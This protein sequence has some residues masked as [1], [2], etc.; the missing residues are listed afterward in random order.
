MKFIYPKIN[1]TMLLSREDKVNIILIENQDLFVELLVDLNDQLNGKKGEAVLSL[2]NVPIPISNNLEIITE[3][4][5]FS[6]N[7]NNLTSELHNQLNNIALS[8]EYY[9]ESKKLE[10]DIINFIFKI[11]SE[12]DFNLEFDEELDFKKILKLIKAKFE[13]NKEKLSEQIIEYMKIVR[14]YDCDKCFVLVDIRNYINDKEIDEFYKL[15]LYNKLRVLIIS[16][17]DRTK[18]DYEEKFII[19]ADLCQF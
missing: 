12:I 9:I 7:F 18:S 4:I 2:D 15:I 1:E 8:E 17:G 11:N 16:G 14:E 13:E 19:D 5:P 3:F 6:V 10:M